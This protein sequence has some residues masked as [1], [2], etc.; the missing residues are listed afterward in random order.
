MLDEPALALVLVEFVVRRA[1]A[2]TDPRHPPAYRFMK[3]AGTPELP[4]ALPRGRVHRQLSRLLEAVLH[5]FIDADA[6]SS[7]L[8]SILGGTS[9]YTLGRIHRHTDT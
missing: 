5:D 3:Y 1:R 7:L 6:D 8:Q 4:L 9:V 2:T